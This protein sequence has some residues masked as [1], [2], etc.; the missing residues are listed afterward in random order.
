MPGLT[1]DDSLSPPPGIKGHSGHCLDLCCTIRVPKPAFP[2]GGIFLPPP[3]SH[4]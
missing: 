2:L 4:T 3:A 1:L